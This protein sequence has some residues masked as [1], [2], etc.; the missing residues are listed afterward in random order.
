VFRRPAAEH[1]VENA[2]KRLHAALPDVRIVVGRWSH[3]S[4]AGEGLQPLTD[5]GAAHVSNSLIDTRKYLA[6]AAHVGTALVVPVVVSESA[7]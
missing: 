3:P 5:A 7:A 4:L 2:L 1:V 6:E